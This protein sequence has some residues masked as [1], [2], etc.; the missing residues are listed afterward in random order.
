MMNVRYGRGRKR[1]GVNRWSLIEFFGGK[2]RN[3]LD[4]YERGSQKRWVNS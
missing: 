3:I 2:K 1:G 4:F